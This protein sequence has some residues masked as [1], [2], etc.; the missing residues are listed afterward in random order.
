MGS[1]RAAILSMV[2]AAACGPTDPTDAADDLPGAG[3]TE[4]FESPYPEQHVRLEETANSDIT[5]SLSLACSDAAGTKENSWYRIFNLTEFG[6][7]EAF[8]VNRVNFGV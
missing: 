5:P 1:W 6:I 4:N 3:A 8:A 2:L 7:D